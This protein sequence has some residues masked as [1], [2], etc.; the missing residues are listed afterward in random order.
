M[1]AGLS[2]EEFL[3]ESKDNNLTAMNGKKMKTVEL[4]MH[5]GIHRATTI[6][7]TSEMNVEENLKKARRVVYRLMSS[8][9]HGYNGLDPETNLHLMKTY[10]L[11]VLLYGLELVLPSKTLINK[12]ETYEKKILKQILSLPTS[13]ADVAVY[14]ISGFLPVEGQIDKKILTLLNNV[15]RKDD[16]SIGK[17]IVIRQLTIKNYK[18]RRWFVYARKT[19]LKYDLG[20]I[21]E[22]LENT[23]CKEYMESN[24]KQIC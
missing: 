14:V 10:V 23:I 3:R 7:K 17:Q 21:H 8:G 16:T 5:L 19:L 15:T 20:D 9:M 2:V 1:N 22:H 18:S 13:T 24:C 4:A 12:L 11:P 6:S